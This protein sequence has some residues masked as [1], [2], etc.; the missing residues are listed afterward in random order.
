MFSRCNQ[1]ALMGMKSYLDRCADNRECEKEH[2]S[3]AGA[4]YKFEQRLS[5]YCEKRFALTFSN[6]TTALQALCLAYNLKGTEILTSPFN[7]GG[8]VTPFLLHGNKLRFTGYEPASMNLR[9]DTLDQGWTKNTKALLSVDFNGYPADSYRIKSFCKDR[10]ITY[11]S[12]SSQCLGARRNG[13]PAGYFADA[14]V[15][16]FS[17]GKTMFGGEGGAV[18]TD[19]EQLYETLLKLAHH[20]NRQKNISGLTNYSEFSLLNGRMNPL[21]AI[22]LYEGFEDSL[23]SLQKK[24]ARLFQIVRQ[25]SLEKLI[26]SHAGFDSITGATWF[27]PI[28]FARDRIRIADIHERCQELDPWIAVEQVEGITPM[29]LNT[30]FQGNFSGSYSLP[31]RTIQQLNHFDSSRY[32]RMIVTTPQCGEECENGL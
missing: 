13:K 23:Q 22:L 12:D 4:T 31:S 28:L 27:R 10:G 17:A 2:L 15:F 32:G 5:S 21:A 7:W 9:A 19:D 8:S 26:T 11:I 24:Q 20:P 6:A 30:T 18:V 25:L 14:T 16:S 1:S 3:G 29:P